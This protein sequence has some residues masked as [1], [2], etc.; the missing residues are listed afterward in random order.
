[1]ALSWATVAAD[2]RVEAGVK[3]FL[4]PVALLAGLGCAHDIEMRFPRNVVG[5]TGT[6]TVVLTEPVDNV[7]VTINGELVTHSKR[8]QRVRVT[9][10]ESGTVDVAV[11][12]GLNDK[13][14]R[15]WLSTDQEITLPVAAAPTPVAGGWVTTAISAAL[16]VATLFLL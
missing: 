7:A 10:V 1:M 8:T 5:S 6:I 14:F 12:A 9:G 3:T 13:Q 2:A 11:A 16:A 4:A 15:V